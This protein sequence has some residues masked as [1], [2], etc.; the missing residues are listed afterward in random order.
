[1][2]EK[3]KDDEEDEKL[4]QGQHRRE[5]R[6]CLVL[7]TFSFLSESKSRLDN[8]DFLGFIFQIVFHDLLTF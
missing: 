4:E 6:F 1:M 5:N 3:N 2:G 8:Y 7:V